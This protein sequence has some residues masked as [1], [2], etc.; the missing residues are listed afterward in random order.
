MPYNLF[1]YLLHMCL[2]LF[3]TSAFLPLLCQGFVKP[4]ERIW[5]R[6]TPYYKSQS[7]LPGK[8]HRSTRL[9]HVSVALESPDMLHSSVEVLITV[10]VWP[11]AKNVYC[12]SE[13]PV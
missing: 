5:I 10:V 12:F 1:S 7:L 6:G 9:V 3:S 11:Q 2:L 8:C 4:A 13:D